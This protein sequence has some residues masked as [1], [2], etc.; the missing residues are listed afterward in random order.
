MRPMQVKVRSARSPQALLFAFIG[1]NATPSLGAKPCTKNLALANE[2]DWRGTRNCES[3]D[4]RPLI[5][6]AAQQWPRDW[7]AAFAS[8]PP[9]WLSAASPMTVATMVRTA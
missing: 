1:E 2:E 5:P 6:I 7:R 4:L 3:R 8:P 9:P